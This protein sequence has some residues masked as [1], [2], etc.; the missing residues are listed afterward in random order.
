MKNKLTLAFMAIVMMAMFASC[1]KEETPTVYKPI[2]Y[3]SV[4]RAEYE[5]RNDVAYKVRFSISNQSSKTLYYCKFR[6][7][8]CNENEVGFYSDVYEVGSKN[9]MSLWSLSPGDIQFTD[10]YGCDFLFKDISGIK[11]EIIDAEFY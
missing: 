8:Q 9:D 3:I 7:T 10:Y 5:I 11:S 6:V 2:D 4:P 1:T